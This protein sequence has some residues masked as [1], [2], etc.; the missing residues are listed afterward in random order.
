MPV[1]QTPVLNVE[2]AASESRAAVQHRIWWRA[3]LQFVIFAAVFTAGLELFFSACGVGMEQILQPDPLLGTKHIPGKMVVW[4]ME[5][6]SREP[7]SSAGLHDEEH[8]LA[9]PAGVYRI[10]LLGDSAT[11]SM[12]VPLNANYGAW[13][14]KL[15]KHPG[16]QTEVLNFGCSGYST[17]QETLQFEQQAAQYKPDLTVLLYNRG[18]AIENVRKPTDLGCEPRPYFYMSGTGKLTEDDAVLKAHSASLQANAL[19]DFLRRNSRIYGVLCQANLNLSIH[20]PLYCKVR[21]WLLSPFTPRTKK[22][23]WTEAPYPPPDA[24]AVTNALVER[25]HADCLQ[26]GSKLVVVTFPNAVQDP[27][28]DGQIKHLVQ[29]A[30]HDG[31]GCFDLTPVFRW[32]PD[33]MSLFLQYHFSAKGHKVVAENITEYLQKNGY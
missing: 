6:F 22:M 1:A 25:L 16:L 10:A 24:W 20:E 14:R 12:Q 3:P 30:K 32:N 17:G 5:G 29:T 33:P 13:L 11:E 23:T 21:S 28:F 31:F 18:D 19:W 7:L 9:K 26:A 15:I 4:R 8:V 2:T 27:E